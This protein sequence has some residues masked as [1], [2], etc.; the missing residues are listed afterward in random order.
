MF[1][2][3]IIGEPLPRFNDWD[4]QLLEFNFWRNSFAGGPR[5]VHALDSRGK[6]VLTKHPREKDEGYEFRINNAILFNYVKPIINRYNDLVF[7][8]TPERSSLDPRLDAFYEDVD[9]YD[10]HMDQIAEKALKCAQIDGKSFLMLD[11][12]YADAGTI[13]QL[14]AERLGIRK[15]L[16]LV[17]ASSVPYFASAGNGVIKQAYVVLYDDE[18]FALQVNDVAWRRISIEDPQQMIVREIGE[19]IIH[20]YVGCPLVMVRP[21]EDTSQASGIS[22][23]QKHVFNLNSLLTEELFGS[24]FTQ[25]IATGASPG[26]LKFVEKGVNRL[27]VVD[28]QGVQ[29]QTLGSD[30]SQATSIRESIKETIQELYRTAGLTAGNALDTSTP[31][32]G[33]ALQFLQNQMTT[34]ASA[35]ARSIEFAEN[36]IVKLLDPEADNKVKY[37]KDFNPIDENAEID[38]TIKVIESSMPAV[39]KKEIV[40][41]FSETMNI[42]DSGIE[43]IVDEQIKRTNPE[44]AESINE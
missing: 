33:V 17:K 28:K 2:Q 32:S 15:I 30:A 16:R 22:E 25:W 27:I 19:W 43:E 8:T 5:Y 3:P 21:D 42:N 10:T 39:I 37:N 34:A 4:R 26:D 44:S 12:N 6:L 38:K 36:K 41:R 29:F 11:S 20:N 31:M 35:L 24:T 18:P 9:D 23:I 14:E 7:S 13:S 40:K 1:K